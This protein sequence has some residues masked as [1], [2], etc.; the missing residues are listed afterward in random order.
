MCPAT[1]TPPLPVTEVVLTQCLPAK[2]PNHRPHLNLTPV[3]IYAPVKLRLPFIFEVFVCNQKV[4][5]FLLKQGNC[6][7]IKVV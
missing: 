1:R 5:I 6:Q 7:E 3:V 2:N 4:L